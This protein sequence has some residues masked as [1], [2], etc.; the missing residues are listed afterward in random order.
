M[1]RTTVLLSS[2]FLSLQTIIAQGC[3]D[4]GFCTMG[5]M[6]PDQDYSKRIDLKLRSIS[7]NYYRGK[8]NISPLVVAHTVDVNLTLND[9]NTI[10]IKL[11]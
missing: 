1:L 3:S 9:L 7:Y 11:P 4:A 5:A 10:Q 2:F 6:R 8:T